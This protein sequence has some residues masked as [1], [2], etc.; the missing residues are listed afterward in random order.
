MKVSL[1][2]RPRWRMALA[3]A[4]SLA[5]VLS[6]SAAHLLVEAESFQKHGGWELDTQFIGIMGSPYLLAH[7]IG[8]PVADATTRVTFPETGA[9]R[10][11][12]RTKDWVARWQAP[13]APG[14][15]QLV[16]NGQPLK[17]TFGTKSADWFWQDGGTVTITQPKGSLGLHD[18]TGFDGRCDAIFFTTAQDYRPPNDSEIMAGW[19]KQLLG[20]PD[21][22]LQG[23]DFDLVVVGGGYAGTAAAVSAARLGCRVA[24]I[25]DRA[26]LGGNGSSEVRVWPQ[27]K[28]RRGLFRV[29]VR[30]WRNWLPIPV[31][32]PV[33]RKSSAMP[34]SWRSFGRKN[35]TLFI[36]HY[37]YQV[38][39]RTNRIVAVIALDT[40]TSQVR[41]F[42]GTTFA[43][44]TGHGTLG[45]LAGAD[46]TSNRRGTWA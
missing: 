38:E 3:M 40:R 37:V 22:P 25:Q 9:Y 33:G 32:L 11:W 39:T 2:L 21:Q 5:W 46:L 34:K 26:V 8:E 15:F 35:I 28:T 13:G 19:R 23:G 45:A 44:C 6:A 14:R 20:L 18:L 4:C 31:C 41:R 1:A 10:V 42:T 12:V 7:G 29:W 36:N 16:V 27:G 24:L 17:E 43:D 30:S